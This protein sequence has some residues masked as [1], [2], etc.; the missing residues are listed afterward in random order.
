MNRKLSREIAMK[1]LFQNSINDIPVSEILHEM[2]AYFDDINLDDLDMKY[3]EE[4]LTGVNNNINTIDET[5]EKSSDNWKINRISKINLAILRISVFEILYYEEVPAKVSIN[6][7][8]ELC[9]TYSD[10]KSVPFVNALLDRIYKS[11]IN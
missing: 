6:E 11:S 5:I 3:I 10:D 8:I 1:I 2:D 9:R 7:A 4:I